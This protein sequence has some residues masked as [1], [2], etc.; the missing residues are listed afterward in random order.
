MASVHQEPKSP[1]HSQHSGSDSTCRILSWLACCGRLKLVWRSSHARPV[2]VAPSAMDSPSLDSDPATTTVHIPSGI[3]RGGSR[4]AAIQIEGPWSR[5]DDPDSVHRH[6]CPIC[7]NYFEEMNTTLC[8]QHNLCQDCFKDIAAR[9]SKTSAGATPPHPPQRR[10]SSRIRQEEAPLGPMPVRD[11]PC[12]ER[13]R[14]LRAT[15]S[16]PRTHAPARRTRDDATR[17]PPPDPAAA[18]AAGAAGWGLR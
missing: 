6:Y 14:A 18:G 13:Q 2:T 3:E 15:S 10:Q 11:V 12:P 17:W 9:F 16:P 5:R 7:M 1:N 8:C 4:P